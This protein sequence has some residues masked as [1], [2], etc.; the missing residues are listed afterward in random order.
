[1][2]QFGEVYLALQ[3]VKPGSGE[4]GGDSWRRAVKMLR[5]SATTADK[6]E[7]LREAETMLTFDHPNLVRLIGVAVQQRPWLTV[8]EYMSVSGS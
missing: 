4:D 2:G 6:T 5:N 3:A 7:F 8:I 1:M